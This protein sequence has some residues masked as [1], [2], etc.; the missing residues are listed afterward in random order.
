LRIKTA[1]DWLLTQKLIL[2]PELDMNASGRADPQQSLGAGLS[3]ASLYEFSRK[4]APY[5]GYGWARKF[6]A[7]GD[8]AR[9][10]G[11]PVTDQH[12]LMSLRLW[13]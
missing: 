3:D 5:I 1:Q 12:L 13:F 9:T 11:Q 6:G 2:T 8:M 4:F 7:T 10:A